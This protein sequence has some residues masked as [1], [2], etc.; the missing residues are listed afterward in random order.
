MR[1]KRYA[2]G[3]ERRGTIKNRVSID[4]RPAIVAQKTW[5]GDWESDTVIGKNHKGGMVTL[6]E[7]KSRYVLAGHIHSKHA[8]GVTAVTTRLLTP[9]K[10]KCHTIT[11]DKGR[12]FAEHEK[13]A[14]E[15]KAD[16][17]F[18]NPYHSWERGLNENNNGLLRQYFP[19]DMELTNI[20]EEQVQDAVERINYR[21][22]KVLGF[23]TPHK[24]FF[25]VKLRYTKQPLAVAL[26][27]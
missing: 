20:T 7:R 9:Y 27:T 10:D 23:R 24:V 13:M 26:R 19:K 22:Q 6:A 25:V 12:E 5:L 3:Q 2:S 18:A 14:A 4:E 1:R 16:I 21:P 17:Y 15:L 8:A 11:F